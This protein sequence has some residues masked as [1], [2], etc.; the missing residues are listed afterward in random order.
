MQ[1]AHV[2]DDAVADDA[3]GVGVHEPGGQQ[4]ELEGLAVDH[5]GVPRVVAARAARDDVVL[6]AESVDNFSLALVPPLGAKH[7]GDVGAHVLITSTAVLQKA[8]F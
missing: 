5:D 1:S 2:N 4:M 3:G 6:A 7:H 8:R